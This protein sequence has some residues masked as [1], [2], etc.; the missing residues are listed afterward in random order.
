M[1]YLKF[2]KSRVTSVTFRNGCSFS[3]MSFK[4]LIKP[5]FANAENVEKIRRENPSLLTNRWAGYLLLS[6]F[7]CLNPDE[8]IKVSTLT[9]F[10]IKQHLL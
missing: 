9:I 4:N 1:L 3:K 7:V 6:L 2:L 5:I 8:V 10:T